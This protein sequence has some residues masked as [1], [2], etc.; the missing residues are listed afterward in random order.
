M[1][2]DDS[3]SPGLN[4]C[5]DPFTT[6][7]APA[8]TESTPPPIDAR[9]PTPTGSTRIGDTSEFRRGLATRM[10]G[11]QKHDHARRRICGGGIA[12]SSN[13]RPPSYHLPRLSYE[14]HQ[15]TPET[16]QVLPA[17][18]RTT[19]TVEDHDSGR[20]RGCRHASLGFSVAGSFD[21][22]TG[23]RA[24]RLWDGPRSR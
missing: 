13:S 24:D 18:P 2:H 12:P 3:P 7:R 8:T 17:G 5:A 1:G 9:T 19:P 14:P 11:A 20:G 21:G 4:R 16:C 6:A 22:I 23:E 10:D 15:G